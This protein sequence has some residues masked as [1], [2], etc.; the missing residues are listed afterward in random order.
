MTNKL[1]EKQRRFVEAY[2]GKAAGNATEAARLAGYKGS[3]N[4]LKAVGS[5]NLT[6]PDIA[7][8]VKKR[9]ES[10][11]LI[12][13]RKARMELLSKIARGEE[14]DVTVSFGKAN[15]IDPKL[16]ERLAA[17]D[18]LAKMSGDYRETTVIE[19]DFVPPVVVNV[20][21]GDGS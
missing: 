18:Q 7:A 1:T 20:V 9:V 19:G 17:M 5:E 3:E 13:D 6:K 10:D 8:A 12:L 15:K 2:M 11:P 4:T 16:K 21:A 14:K